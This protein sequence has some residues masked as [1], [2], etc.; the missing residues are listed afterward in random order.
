MEKLR[1]QL[2]CLKIK[3]IRHSLLFLFSHFIFLDAECFKSKK[4][5]IFLFKYSF[6]KQL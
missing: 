3:V 4:N 6:A 5:G 2:V 1:V